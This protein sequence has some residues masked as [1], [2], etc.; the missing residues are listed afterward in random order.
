MSNSHYFSSKPSSKDERALIKTVLRGKRVEFFTS[1]GIFSAK[2]VDNGTRVLV[3]NMMIPE[4]GDFLDIGCGIG[5]IGI[6]AA[7]ESPDL[8][9]HLSDVNSRA[10]KLTRLNVQ[11]HGLVNCSVYEGDLY[12]PLDNRMFDV[13]VS[14][15]PVS[16]GMHKV[17]LPMVSGAFDHLVDGGVLQ[18]VIQTNKG[19]NMLAGFFDDV[20]GS[21]EVIARKSGYRVFSS[22]RRSS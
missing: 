13:I 3:E 21:H 6:I 14:N 12:T 22:V 17:V 15:P 2:R 19:G 9:V 5:V 20:F 1:Q 7:L 16:A 8:R 4:R 10:V 18:M 11:R